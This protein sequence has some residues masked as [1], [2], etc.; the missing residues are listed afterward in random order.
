MKDA[1]IQWLACNVGDGHGWEDWRI[2]ITNA[3][4]LGVQIFPW[5]RCR[6]VEECYRLCE[7]ADSVG[8]QVLLNVED[9]FQG[10]VSPTA[11]ATILRDFPDLQPA[12]STVGW[13][14]N[15]VDYSPLAAVPAL[16]QLFM[17][18]MRRDPADLEQIQKDCCLHARERGFVYLGVTYQTY[19]AAKPEWYE[20]WKG[21]RSY[22]SGD[23]IGGSWAD[24]AWA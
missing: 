16:L 22:Y 12:I 23:D 18:D 1:G 21:P 11:V 17:Q 3:R 10:G 19:G 2:V 13:V 7:I 20:F 6:T 4:L 24:W 8:F 14:Y 9:E 5:A 15:N